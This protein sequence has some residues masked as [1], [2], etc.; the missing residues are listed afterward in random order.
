MVRD[1]VRLGVGIACLPLSLVSRDI[2]AG[3]LSQ[4]GQ[5]DGSDIALWALYP[6]RRFL[7]ARVSA[8]LNHLKASFPSGAPEELAALIDG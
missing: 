4:W 3:R 6:S 1:T 5:L 2:A 8:F 7:S